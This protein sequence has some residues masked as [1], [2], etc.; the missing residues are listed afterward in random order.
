MNP[1][2]QTLESWKEIAAYLQRD[3]KTARRWEKEE[4][5][6]VHRHSHSVR[7]SVYAYPSEID[8]WRA[9]RRLTPEPAARRLWK[10][11]A[12]AVTM[13]LCL[14][15]AG[16]GIRPVSA[17]P[18]QPA[19]RQIWLTSP[20]QEPG[21]VSR[22]GRYIAFTDW[23]TGDLFVRDVSTGTNRRLTDSRGAESGDFAE[24]AAISPDNRLVAYHW[25]SG[26]ELK[27]ELRIVP[28]NGGSPRTVY[29]GE[30]GNGIDFMLPQAWSQDQKQLLVSHALPDQ[31]TQVV[32]LSVDNGSARVIKTVGWR[33]VNADLSPDG[34]YIAYD[35]PAENTRNRD[36]FVVAT[37]GS[38]G[39]AVVE[40]PADDG[41][42][43]WTPDGSRILFVSTRTGNMSL[44]SV[45]MEDGEPKGAAELV[46][47]DIRLESMWMAR[48]GTLHYYVPGSSSPNI[49]SAELDENMKV[50]K[51][52]AL[53]TEKFVNSNNGPGLSADGQ[54]LAYM[55]FRAEKGTLVVRTL[56]TGEEREVHSQAHVGMIRGYG[57]MWFPDGR[58]VLVLTREPQKPG[59]SF[60]RV[61]LDS[62][63]SELV[64]RVIQPVL[65]GYRLSPDGKALFYTEPS[66]TTLTTRLMRFDLESKTETELKS[67][68]LF[69]T[70][71][72]SP[73]S[74]RLAY[75]AS[76]ASG[77]AS[78]IA[79]M[80]A[81]GG[82]SREVYRGSNWTDMSRYNTLAW[83]PDQRFLMFVRGGAGA[84][85]P[86]VL[87]RVPAT[88]GPPEQMYVSAA[89][90]IASPQVQ[91][92]GKRIFF[93]GSERTGSEVWAL[94][95][96]LP[97]A[98]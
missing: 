85:S 34:R 11:P 47:P 52:P 22:D 8:A 78:Y 75:V 92:D 91:P 58:S 64:H 94:E 31:T 9:G 90:G 81:A 41:E 44:W 48:N 40:N 93:A 49:Y 62:G 65:Y 24:T 4:G 77:G 61:E 88:V 7:S 76:A 73:D 54:Y 60:Y 30:S 18:S 2:K 19:A 20:S 42:P 26:K 70:V 12:F 37:D 45:A 5:L 28:M 3:A 72:V 87:W 67:G 13:L 95:N 53:A 10:I 68:E 84:G 1:E 33:Y 23:T 17:Q 29:R 86:S 55:S 16:N 43:V 66:T 50:S 71:A 96:F 32:M 14:I 83:T 35:S 21:A 69:I 51:A 27:H 46:K 98:R 79:V 15:M 25:F 80:P 74:K 82:E 38:R 59:F 97:K 6:P 63:K 56:K 36:I 89:T 39:G 57:P